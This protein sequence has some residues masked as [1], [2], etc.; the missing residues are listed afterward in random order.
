MNPTILFLDYKFVKIPK[1][2]KRPKI[3]KKDKNNYLYKNMN[4][5]VKFELLL[6]F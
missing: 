1:R 2:P 6:V 4:F 3:L 5:K